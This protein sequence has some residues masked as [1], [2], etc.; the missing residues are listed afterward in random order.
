MQAAILSATRSAI[1]AAEMFEVQDKD[2]Q[3]L[4]ISGELVLRVWVSARL[5]QR[6]TNLCGEATDMLRIP[7]GVRQV[8]GGHHVRRPVMLD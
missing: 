4:R 6:I 2:S 1:A 7:S 8:P 3:T 5:R